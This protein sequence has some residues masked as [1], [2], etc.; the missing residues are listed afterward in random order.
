MGFPRQEYWG[1]FLFPRLGDFPNLDLLHWEVD[2]L[3]LSY[4]GNPLT[5]YSKSFFFS[6][7]VEM[8]FRGLEKILSFTPLFFFLEGGVMDRLDV[9]LFE[10]IRLFDSVFVASLSGIY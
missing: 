8:R 3:P 6:P 2:S 4:L 9:H 10:L 7:F 5:S 1:G